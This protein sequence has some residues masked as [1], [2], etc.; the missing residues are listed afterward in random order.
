MAFRGMF[1]PT[2]MAP[3][4]TAIGS[5]HPAAEL[6]VR[7]VA[8]CQAGPHPVLRYLSTMASTSNTNTSFGQGSSLIGVYGSLDGSGIEPGSGMGGTWVG[9]GQHAAQRS[10]IRCSWCQLSAPG[11][12]GLARLAPWQPGTSKEGYV[13]HP[14]AWDVGKAFGAPLQRTWEHPL[15]LLK[16]TFFSRRVFNFP[17]SRQLDSPS[18]PRLLLIRADRVDFPASWR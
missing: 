16:A 7:G 17:I 12:P 8:K 13:G 11:A 15:G 9:M 6:W 5:H 2:H 14:A 3:D 10:K 4:L 1:C 18:S